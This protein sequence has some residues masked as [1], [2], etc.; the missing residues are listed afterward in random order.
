MFSTDTNWNK[1]SDNFIASARPTQEPPSG[2]RSPA[3]KQWLPAGTARTPWFLI[4]YSVAAAEL[5]EHTQCVR[6]VIKPQALD[7][8]WE[9]CSTCKNKDFIVDLKCNQTHAMQLLVKCLDSI[10]IFIA[11]NFIDIL[12]RSFYVIYVCN[13]NP[14]RK[15]WFS[16]IYIFR[17]WLSRYRNIMESSGYFFSRRNTHLI[18][19]ICSLGKEGLHQILNFCVD[20]LDSSKYCKYFNENL[21][22]ITGLSL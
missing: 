5:S 3:S 20:I 22:F 8:K 12:W 21:I 18:Q 11:K 10:I 9:T 16:K 6:P 14:I 4:I 7:C 2:L 1:L 15:F 19:I 13:S 17:L